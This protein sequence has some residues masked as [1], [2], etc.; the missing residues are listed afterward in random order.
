[1]ARRLIGHVGGLAGPIH[2][3][4]G[5]IALLDRLHGYNQAARFGPWLVLVDLDRHAECAPIARGLWLPD[6]APFMCF[7]IVIQEIEAWLLGDQDRL[8]SFLRVPRPMIPANPD[9]L[10]DPKSTVVAL[11]R[12][13]RI[14]SIREDMVPAPDSGRSEGPAFTSRLI[15]FV[16]DSVRG[17][18]PEI[19]ATLSPSLSRCLQSLRR[20]AERYRQSL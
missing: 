14:R 13:S 12:R 2:G 18:R 6:P 17:W 9:V 11:A 1:M 7:R 4:S 5:R 20:I 15:E 19:A 3:K 16:M 8:A 10:A